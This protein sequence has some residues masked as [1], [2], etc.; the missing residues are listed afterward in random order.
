M[1]SGD[2]RRK[3]LYVAHR[4][5]RRIG[6]DDRT[7]FEALRPWRVGIADGP[8]GMLQTSLRPK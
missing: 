7:E 4:V 3:R 5:K 1:V 2:Q 6:Y 8:T